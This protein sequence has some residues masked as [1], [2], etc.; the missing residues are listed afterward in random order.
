MDLEETRDLDIR[1]D[2]SIDSEIVNPSPRTKQKY[3]GESNIYSATKLNLSPNAIDSVYELIEMKE[4]SK[5]NSTKDDGMTL[6]T[7]EKSESDREMSMKNELTKTLELEANIN[8]IV[9]SWDENTLN[10]NSLPNAKVK[11]KIR[12]KSKTYVLHTFP[13]RPTVI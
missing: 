5:T 3:E 1:K 4:K 7:M 8:E 2:G 13:F 11:S 10:T 9:G 12:R 6:S